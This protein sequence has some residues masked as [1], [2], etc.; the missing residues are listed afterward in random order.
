ML[1]TNLGALLLSRFE[2]TGERDVLDEAVRV[3]RDATTAAPP[4]HADRGRHLSNLGVALVHQARISDKPSDSH[5]AIDVIRQALEV[6][7]PDD[8]G[9]AD[10]LI[11]MGA[12]CARAFELGDSEALAAGLAAFREAAGME[13][14]S[15]EARIRAGRDGGRL[16]AANGSHSPSSPTTRSSVSPGHQLAV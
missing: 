10:T 15:S 3:S 16:A 13:I 8:P 9:R 2:Q 4:E 1:L 6:V 12:A 7:G 14:A 11:A 5:T